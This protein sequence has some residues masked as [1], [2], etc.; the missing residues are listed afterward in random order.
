MNSSGPYRSVLRIPGFPSFLWTQFLNAFNDNAY[1]LTVS[2]LA[3]QAGVKP[4]LRL[5]R[6][7]DAWPHFASAVG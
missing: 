5:L 7:L 3:A 1:K 4:A 2:L 6:L